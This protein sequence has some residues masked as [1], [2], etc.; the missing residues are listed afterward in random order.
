MSAWSS[1]KDPQADREAQNYDNPIPSREYIAAY[2]AEVSGPVSQG[3]LASVFKLDRDE[4]QEEALRR[5]LRAMERDGQLIRNR[6]GAYGLVDK[7]DLIR[8]RVMGHRDGFGFVLPEDGS[9][10]LFLSPRQMRLVFDGDRILARVSG[11][12][13]RGRK[14]GHIVEVL[15]HNT[16]NIVGRFYNES[17]VIFVEPDNRRINQDILIAR[18]NCGD[19]VTGQVVVVE[20][21]VHPGIRTQPQG[22][23]INILGDHMAPGMEIDIALRSHEIPFEWP[24]DVLRQTDLVPTTVEE[25]AKLQRI[26]LRHLHLVT[27]D[28]E[29]A[30]DFDDAVYCEEK[31]SGGVAY[32]KLM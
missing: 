5:R 28:G 23:V 2:L 10:D 26:D 11:I 31:K 29:D 12:D 24:S 9:E 8:G 21:I 22:R 4:V 3:Q 1:D 18:E 15:E 20:I 6:K 14:E 25:S 7:M 32:K 30:R 16:T 27:I 19:A 17:G 13:R